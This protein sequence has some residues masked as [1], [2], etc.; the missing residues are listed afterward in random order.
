MADILQMVLSNKF[1]SIKN[2][3]FLC[4]NISETYFYGPSKLL[5]SA[6]AGNGF[7]LS[8]SK[9]LSEPKLMK[10]YMLSGFSVCQCISTFNSISFC[11]I[12]LTSDHRKYA[13]TSLGLRPAN[14]RCRYDVTTSL[15]G[16][17]HT[18]TDPWVC[19]MRVDNWTL[20]MPWDYGRSR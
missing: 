20:K 6:G 18:L 1:P 7:V 14:E 13:A 9:P 2:F 19:E 10:I 4:G 15:I 11:F 17:A 5:I 12:L 8:E 16:W 3:D